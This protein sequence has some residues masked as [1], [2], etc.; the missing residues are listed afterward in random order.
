MKFA[1]TVEKPVWATGADNN[2]KGHRGILGVG[3]VRHLPPSQIVEELKRREGVLG[4]HHHLAAIQVGQ[5]GGMGGRGKR[6]RAGKKPGGGGDD[7][8]GAAPVT[9]WRAP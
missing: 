4:H 2:L 9:D 6:K 7:L 5:V 8:H 3:E 1:R